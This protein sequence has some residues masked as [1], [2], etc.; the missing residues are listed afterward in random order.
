MSYQS[1][2]NEGYASTKQKFDDKYYNLTGLNMSFRY[3]SF[4]EL[5]KEFVESEMEDISLSFSSFVDEGYKDGATD[6]FNDL[7]SA[8]TQY[9]MRFVTEYTD[10]INIKF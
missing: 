4:Y 10:D 8:V 1:Q 6:A 3:V 2:Y 5:A 9:K 7:K